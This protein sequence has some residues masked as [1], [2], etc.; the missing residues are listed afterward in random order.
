VPIVSFV[1]GRFNVPAFECGAAGARGLARDERIEM[2][3][4]SSYVR[5]KS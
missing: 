1:V 4:L 3:R 5:S 2:S